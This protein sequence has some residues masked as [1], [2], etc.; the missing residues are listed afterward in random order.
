MKRHFTEEQVRDLVRNDSNE[1]ELVEEIE[2]DSGR[3]TQY[4]YAIVKMHDDGRCYGL[5]WERGLTELQENEF[6]EG[7]YDEVE[8]FEEVKVIK[9]WRSVK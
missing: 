5:G 9:S 3:W 7:D 6:Y 1:G 8:P 4:I 2:S